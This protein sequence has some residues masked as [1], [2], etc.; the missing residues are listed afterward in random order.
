MALT[1]KQHEIDVVKWEKSVAMGAD[2]CGTFEFCALCD[3]ALDN[4]CDRAL[5]EYV[6]VKAAEKAEL[7]IQV[8]TDA[9]KAEYLAIADRMRALYAEKNA[10]KNIG[11]K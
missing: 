7:V 4:P 8:K 6:A 10:F 11:A 9:V 1:E 2:A 5:R 3:K